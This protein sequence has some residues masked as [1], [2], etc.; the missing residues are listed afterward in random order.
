M[1]KM[2]V[3]TAGLFLAVLCSPA[4]ALAHALLLRSE[5]ANREVLLSSPAFLVLHFS[6]APEIAMT[7]ILLTDFAGANVI[8][9]PVARFN[10]DPLVLSLAVGRQLGAGR[11]TVTWHTAA[12]DGHPSHGSYYFTV[13]ANPANALAVAEGAI[14]A[15]STSSLTQVAPTGILRDSSS[16]NDTAD[17]ILS[18]V[19]IITRAI[20]FAALLA[21]VGSV[22]FRLGVLTQIAEI[23]AN[24]R[25][26]IVR[27]SASLGAV[28]AAVLVASALE[29]LHLQSQMMSVETGEAAGHLSVLT[30]HTDWGIAWWTQ[31]LGGLLALAG[32]MLARS[33][34]RQGWG[35]AALA[36]IPIVISP[37]LGGHAKA[38]PNLTILSVGIDS[39]HVFGA[40]CWLGTLLA[41][42]VAGISGMRTVTDGTAGRSIAALVNAFSPIALSAAS[43]VALTGIVTAWLRLDS[44]AA[45]W[46]STYGKILVIKLIAVVLVVFAGAFNWR[47][48][49]PRLG[50]DSATGKLQRSAATELALALV[51]LIITAILVATPTRQ[52]GG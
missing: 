36:I 28:A 31:V 25:A 34:R 2:R 30:M 4:T 23:D 27:R 11:Y 15:S 29:R 14:T 26:V 33:G 1:K 44:I 52:P 3:I 42:L 46:Q 45:L 24:T 50:E 7:T 13:R 8:I 21:V 35:I 47:S 6:E 43:L 12:S 32:L 48:M 40:S 22:M 10:G 51:V 17:A 39:L 37:A 49:R 41:M 5:P 9:G 18:P 16:S 38:A 19:A 20:E